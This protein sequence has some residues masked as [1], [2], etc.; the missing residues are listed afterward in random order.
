M[1]QNSQN[2][3]KIFLNVIG[4][5]IRRKVTK[6]TEGAEERTNKNGEKVYELC[7]TSLTAKIES[8]S[9]R[10]SEFNGEK[11]D[12]WE[13]VLSDIGEKYHLQLPTSG[14]ITNGFMF[15]LPNTDVSKDIEVVTFTDKENPDRTV[16]ILKQDGKTVPV[17]YKKD[18]PNGLPQLEK[19]TFKGKEVWD[20]TKQQQFIRNMVET[21][22]VPKLSQAPKATPPVSQVSDVEDDGQLPF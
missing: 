11:V 18:A 21:T 7:Y 20:D 13:V 17:A 5:K 2:Q 16:L 9:I 19:I 14:R 10:Q 6:D 4:G 1:L 22:I 3:S 12:N 8:I 15:R